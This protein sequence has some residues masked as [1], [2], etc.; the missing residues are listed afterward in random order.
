MPAFAHRR[1][2]HGHSTTISSACPA[3]SLCVARGY[4]ATS[5]RA[6]N[7]CP[8]ETRTD[9]PCASQQQPPQESAARPRHDDRG[10][11][12][13][14]RGHIPGP[15]AC[16]EQ[17]TRCVLTM[18]LGAAIDTSAVTAPSCFPSNGLPIPASP[19]MQCQ[20]QGAV[21]CGLWKRLNGLVQSQ[22]QPRRPITLY[23]SFF[24]R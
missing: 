22:Q 14:Q 18:L 3:C 11:C 15:R 6:I 20:R 13:Y 2:E 4:R 21:G 19:P 1:Q 23:L 17:K 10:I 16:C 24:L 8:A 12:T 5:C 7:I 9:E